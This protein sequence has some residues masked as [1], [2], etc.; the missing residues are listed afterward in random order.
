MKSRE[1]AFLYYLDDSYK[2]FATGHFF[3]APQVVDNHKNSSWAKVDSSIVEYLTSNRAK[4]SALTI[5]RYFSGLDSK[6]MLSDP[7]RAVEISV[8]NLERFI[9]VGFVNELDTWYQEL[10]KLFS[11]KI[12]YNQKNASPKKELFNQLYSNQSIVDRVKTLANIDIQI[13]EKALK[14]SRNNQNH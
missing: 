8:K 5:F 3:A 6:G 10:E 4:D 11:C 7:E 1:I 13:F 9:S 2:K 12:K 14:I